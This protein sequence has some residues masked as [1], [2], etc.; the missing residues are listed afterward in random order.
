MIRRIVPFLLAPV[1][2]L[3]VVLGLLMG[4]DVDRMRPMIERRL[5][6]AAGR[7]V[8]IGAIHRLDHGLIAT[9]QIQDVRVSQPDWAGAGDMLRIGRATVRL[10]LLP[11]LLGQLH[12]RSID[13]DGMHVALVRLD[14][15]R[16]NWR[17]LPGGTGGGGGGALQR[18]TIRN[19][20]LTM[21]D[22]KQDHRF[23]ARVSADAGGFRLAGT[24]SLAGHPSTIALAGPA[25]T[26]TGPW[27]FRL[28][29]RSA[30]ANTDMAG[31]AD[32]ALD[33]GHFAADVTAWGD[34]LKHLDLLVEAGLPATQPVRLTARIRHDRP[35]WTIRSLAARIG[36][37]SFTLAMQI[38]K[39]GDRT[40][41][42]GTMQSDGFD[43]DDLASDAG[44]AHA[45][46]KKRI[47]GPRVVPDTL[48]DLQHLRRL[49]GTLRF[50]IR[51]LLFRR[52]SAL[53][54]AKG[55]IVLD[56]GVMTLRPLSVALT[57]GRIEGTMSVRHATGTPLL[58]LDLALHD[59][60]VEGLTGK[61][62]VASGGLAARVHLAGH[63]RT[64]RQAIGR[65][66][67]S[68][69]VVVRNGALSRKAA[70]FLGAD[71]GRALFEDKQ[72]QTPLRCLV[73]RFDARD[74]LARTNPLLLDTAV[75]QVDGNGTINL[76]DEALSI[77]LTGQPKL[78]S[79]VSLD[80]PV[81]V[82]GTVSH[83]RVIPPE[84]PK[85]VGTVFKLIGKAI[86]GGSR[87]TVGDAD[88]GGLSARVLR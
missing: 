55:K 88:C 4:F 38:D 33:L 71:V 37:S 17:D 50:D 10:P 20:I 74:G 77:R 12:L 83:P 41:L 22:R 35:D 44:L 82:A 23:V 1:V 68:I 70:L 76:A 11:L 53:R 72:Q 16:A 56:H 81:Y 84:V 47:V 6:A 28:G 36:R 14:A 30:I 69:G 49:D 25:I 29:Y 26:R 8:R 32:D 65:S 5:S 52:P 80:A 18:L 46:E 45:A 39:R 60:R 15:A 61:T 31:V 66:D 9:V 43:F 59:G 75:S 21:D 62:D 58:T 54:S 3:C 13:V 19:G 87:A 67:G 86:G 73:A 7:S 34:D 48:I 63:G 85:T 64:I 42:D 40:L 27:P 2:L 24:G 79:A 57:R 51:Q 78:K